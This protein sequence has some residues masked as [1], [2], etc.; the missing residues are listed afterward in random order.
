MVA[1]A[2]ISEGE[3]RFVVPMLLRPSELSEVDPTSRVVM[4]DS[5]LVNNGS[6]IDLVSG[7]DVEMLVYGAFAGEDTLTTG[8][9]DEGRI[10][11]EVTVV[12]DVDVEI[13]VTF[14]S[15]VLELVVVFVC[16]MEIGR[17][18]VISIE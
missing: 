12:A 11:I 4:A 10:P 6:V 9:L 1:V 15:C 14:V 8:E 3:R 18:E 2:G 5:K 13:A 7:D 16:F 17:W